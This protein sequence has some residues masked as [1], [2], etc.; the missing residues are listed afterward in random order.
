[1]RKKGI[2]KSFWSLVPVCPLISL[3]S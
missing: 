3:T 2:F 1:L